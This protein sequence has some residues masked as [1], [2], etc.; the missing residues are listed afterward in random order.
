[1][2]SENEKK[3]ARDRQARRREKMEKN[4]FKRTTVWIHVESEQQGKE[5]ATQGEAFEPIKPG[6]R[7]AA[8]WALGWI[9]EKERGKSQ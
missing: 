9:A 8:S 2:I 7:D 5:A 1:M 4:G 3:L 6:V